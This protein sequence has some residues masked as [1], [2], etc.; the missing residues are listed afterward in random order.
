MLKKLTLAASFA[1][2]AGCSILPDRP[3]LN[4]Y[5]FNIT[6]PPAGVVSAKKLQASVRVNLPDI[7]APY[8][9]PKLFIKGKDSRFYSTDINR[10]VASP[11]EIIGNDLRQ[12]LEKTGPWSL[13]LS[14]NSLASPDYQMTIY[15]S[16]L[17]GDAA[18]KQ[19]GDTVISMEVSVTRAADDKLVFHKN[20]RTVTPIA[21]DSISSLVDSYSVGMTKIFEDLSRNL[22]MKFVGRP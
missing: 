2:L 8:N 12:W 10:L 21:Q 9:G 5:D 3:P 18:V 11:N 19:P 22:N 6:E 4:Y 17:Y 20:Y 14:P 1:F 7:A 15:V 13:V 16:E